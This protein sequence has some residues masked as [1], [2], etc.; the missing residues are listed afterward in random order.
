MYTHFTEGAVCSWLG[1]VFVPFLLQL[2]FPAAVHATAF[3]VLLCC[4]TYM[5]LILSPCKPLNIPHHYLVIL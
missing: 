3:Y 2:L 1:V 4:V 5:H